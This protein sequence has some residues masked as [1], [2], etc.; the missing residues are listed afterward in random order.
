MSNSQKYLLSAFFM[1]AALLAILFSSREFGPEVQ[2][3][4]MQIYQHPDIDFGFDF[5]TLLADTD[6]TNTDESA[7]LSVLAMSPEACTPC[8]NNV[9]DLRDAIN[10]DEAIQSLVLLFTNEPK[11]RVSHF[12]QTSG[13]EIPYIL[14]NETGEIRA[15]EPMQYI[16]F[17]DSETKELFYS[18]PI[19]NYTTPFEAKAELL[20]RVKQA[21]VDGYKPVN[22]YFK[23]N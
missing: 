12:V 11:W 19:P 1:I 2:S 14:K 23:E 6:F 15:T 4:A 16:L 7:I 9:A 3:P 8:L 13:L 17:V 21:W 18:E 10:A 5:H 20:A 22:E